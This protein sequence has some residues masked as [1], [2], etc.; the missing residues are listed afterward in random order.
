MINYAA[1]DPNEEKGGDETGEV[2][3]ELIAARIETTVNM[4]HN[5]LKSCEDYS[6]VKAF[7]KFLDVYQTSEGNIDEMTMKF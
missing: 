7:Q 2:N 1:T 4:F 6:K 3:K 5:V